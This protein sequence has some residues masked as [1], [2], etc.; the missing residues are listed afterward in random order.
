MAGNFNYR[1]LVA[2]LDRL[3]LEIRY[4]FIRFWIVKI[5]RNAYKIQL[6]FHKDRQPGDKVITGIND[7]EYLGKGYYVTLTKEVS[8]KMRLGARVSHYLETNGAAKNQFIIRNNIIIG[9]RYDRTKK[10][11]RVRTKNTIRLRRAS[12]RKP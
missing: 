3:G 4:F 6:P 10:R 8:E 1:A 2:Y 12:L 7:L 11:G 9:E 5:M